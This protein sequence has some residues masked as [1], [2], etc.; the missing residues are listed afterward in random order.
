QDDDE[1]QVDEEEESS[2]ALMKG[3]DCVIFLVDASPAMHTA[4]D[5][6]QTCFQRIL[7]TAASVLMN[8]II[9][10]PSDLM[11]IV[12][13]GT[14]ESKNELNVDNIYVFQELEQP[15]A[16][17][18]QDLESLEKV[19]Y[20][21][22]FLMTN[23]D[24]PNADKVQARTAAATRAK[25]LYDEGAKIHLFALPPDGREFDFN[26]FFR[27][28]IPTSDND[29]D[30]DYSSSAVNTKL[31]DLH[32]QVRQKEFRKRKAFGVPFILGEDFQI[33]VAGYALY[34]EVK[35][36]THTW[37]LGTTNDEIKIETTYMCNTTGQTLSSADMD[38]A[39][40]Y[41]GQ[42]VRNSRFDK[43]RAHHQL[44]AV[45][46]KDE[47]AEMK[48]FADPGTVI[49][50]PSSRVL[51]K[52]SSGLRLIGFKP[53]D[54]IFRKPYYN[55]GHSTFVFPDEKSFTGS[56]SFFIQFVARVHKLKKVVIC[57]F[58]PRTNANPRLVA[59]IP[60]IETFD[61][62]GELQRPSGFHMLPMPFCDDIRRPPAHKWDGSRV[63]ALKR[64]SDILGE[65]MDKMSLKIFSLDDYPN[66]MIQSHYANLQAVALRKDAANEVDDATRPDNSRI[67]RRC[68]NLF[69]SFYQALPDDEEVEPVVK[70]RKAPAG[71]GAVK[72]AA[73][74]DVDIKAVQDLYDR[75]SLSK[76]TVAQLQAFLTSVKIKPEK[77]K[78]DLLEQVEKYLG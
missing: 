77:K 21:R 61:D 73:K 72:K 65:A 76:L 6:G 1:E 51:P 71:G 31:D 28:I 16:K 26:A 69:E 52:F 46:T 58:L 18:I 67:M 35:P 75:G 9:M 60:Q 32:L 44:Q 50:I 25:D 41:G 62:L 70:K 23:N 48:K 68:A 14:R 30:D 4:T 20:K 54:R 22:V 56:S 8:Q 36:P 57:S 24:H 47:V 15:S 27:N 11:G 33:G 12:F 78:G 40:P 29:K 59:L 37:L 45:F 38:S 49:I 66:P 34:A 39:Y 42:M 63:D 3:R 74:P 5:T 10:S 53:M 17:K 7:H 13:Y 64:A 55:V 19:D 2:E 43:C